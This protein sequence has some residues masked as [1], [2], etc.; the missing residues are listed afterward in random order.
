MEA[1][2]DANTKAMQENQETTT[3]MDAKIGSIQDELI[4]TIKNFKLNG[5]ET[6]ACQE[7]MEA[8]FEAEEPV[9]VD[10]TPEVADDQE[11]PVEDAEVLSVAKRRKRRRDGRNLAAVRRHKKKQDQNLDV[12]RRREGQE[13][14]QRKMGA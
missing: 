11:V 12:G 3:R 14:A 7:T 8:R 6:T 1:R 5:K 9:S 2:M 4:S 13:W 10:T